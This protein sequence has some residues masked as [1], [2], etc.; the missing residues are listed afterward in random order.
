M[1]PW[2]K[3]ERAD[4]DFPEGSHY[5]TLLVSRI[6]ANGSTS[7][8]CATQAL[9]PMQHKNGHVALRPIARRLIIVAVIYFVHRI[10]LYLATIKIPLLYARPGV[11]TGATQIM[12]LAD[13]SI[14]GLGKWVGVL[15][16][17]PRKLLR[18]PGPAL[19]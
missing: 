6:P 7:Y 12:G 18:L 5:C 10:T 1:K 3:A 16:C 14:Q 15:A 13:L 4:A 9:K 2:L 8:T 17:L 11:L 19:L